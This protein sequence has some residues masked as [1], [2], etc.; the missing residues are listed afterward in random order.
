MRNAIC[1]VCGF[2]YPAGTLLKRW[3]GLMVCKRDW[4]PRHPQDMPQPIRPER[5]P[6]WTRP[7]AADTFA[8][9]SFAFAVEGENVMGSFCQADFAAAD[10]AEVDNINGG[11]VL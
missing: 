1:D 2:K 7:E 10:Y 5:P 3:D 6:A 8:S 9:V 11:L 4:E